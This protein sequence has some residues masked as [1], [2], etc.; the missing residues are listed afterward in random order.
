MGCDV[1]TCVY[2][3]LLDASAAMSVTLLNNSSLT[4]LLPNLPFKD[5][6]RLS[7]FI[8]PFKHRSKDLMISF[9]IGDTKSL[10]WRLHFKINPKSI[11]NHLL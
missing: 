4:S 6:I 8:Q 5:V 7:S 1:A 9:I 2:A 10:D 11:N 3:R